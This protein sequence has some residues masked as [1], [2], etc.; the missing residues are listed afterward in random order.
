LVIRESGQVEQVAGESETR[1]G[2]RS[3]PRPSEQATALASGDRLILVSDGVIDRPLK[4]GGKLGLDGVADAARQPDI[5][6]A[7]ATVR[8]VH[9]AV[10]TCSDT[11]L[12]DDAAAICLAL[13]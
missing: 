9:D 10:L 4:A 8:S 3:R 11:D 6:G 13:H 5:E 1:L 2:G 12:D 7:A